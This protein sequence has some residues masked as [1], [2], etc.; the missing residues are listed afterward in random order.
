MIKQDKNNCTIEGTPQL[1]IN[2]AAN[3]V[4]NIATSICKKTKVSEEEVLAQIQQAI[5]I[6]TLITAGMSIDD[7][8]D[9]ADPKHNIIKVIATEEDGSTTTLKER[10]HE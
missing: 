1:I 9:I 8:L 10:S 6:N 4:L 3:L 5:Q 2:E 7:A